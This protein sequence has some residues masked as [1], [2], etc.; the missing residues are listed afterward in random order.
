MEQMGM[1]VGNL[2]LNPKGDHMAMAQ[3][4]CDP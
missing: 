2:E 3:A 1:V 4:F